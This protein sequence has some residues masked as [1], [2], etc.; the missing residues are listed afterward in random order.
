MLSDQSMR[1]L[2]QRIA[3]DDDA[4]ARVAAVWDVPPAPDGSAPTRSQ[5]VARVWDH[6][7]ARSVWEHLAEDER[8]CLLAVL[9]TRNPAAGVRRETVQQQ[10]KLPADRCAAALTRLAQH[11]FLLDEEEVTAHPLPL[12]RQR[13]RVGGR[14]APLADVG[15]LVATALVFPY[16]ECYD[17]LATTGRD[18]RT[19]FRLIQEA[20]LARLLDQWSWDAVERL[21]QHP[22]LALRFPLLPA[23]GASSTPASGSSSLDL[24]DQL[25]HL[26]RAAS[27]TRAGSATGSSARPPDLRARISERLHD[28]VVVFAGLQDLPVAQG[29]PAQQLFLWLVERGGQVTLDEARAYAAHQGWEP[30]L[31]DATVQALTGLALAFDT[32]CAPAAPAPLPAPSS[33]ATSVPLPAPAPPTMP[34]TS[35]TSLRQGGEAIRRLFLPVDL[36]IAIRPE[37]LQR[38]ADERHHAFAPVAE[39]PPVTRL[40]A[41]TIL[42]DLAFLTGATFQQAIAPTKDGAIPKRLVAT[43]HAGLYGAHGRQ[44]LQEP[45]GG[46]Q[47][48]RRADAL[49]DEDERDQR[50]P[51]WDAPRRTPDP[52]EDDAPDDDRALTQR[53]TALRELGVLRLGAPAPGD[54]PQYQPGSGLAAWSQL[55]IEAQAQRFLSWWRAST[56]WT[57]TWALARSAGIARSNA[58]SASL[59]QEDPQG[60]QGEADDT[61]PSRVT[62]FGASGV[63]TREALLAVLAQCLPGR[64]YRLDAILFALWKQQPLRLFTAP[65]PLIRSSLPAVW[66]VD[67]GQTGPGASSPARPTLQARWLQWRQHNGLG[68]TALLTT[69]LHALGVIALGWAQDAD[70]VPIEA[71]APAWIQLTPLGASALGVA[72][73]TASAADVSASVERGHSPMATPSATPPLPLGPSGSP[74]ATPSAHIDADPQ[75]RSFQSLRRV[76]W[77]CGARPSRVAPRP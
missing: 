65:A 42:Y 76:G 1:S 7:A 5:V 17:S 6:A 70:E 45:Q 55:S 25:L 57:D 68:F 47:T 60:D 34:L 40:G 61:P 9:Q 35:P 23:G 62:L 69:T 59:R 2:R 67:P 36:L 31:F 30:Y 53:F 73:L 8:R 44:A 75:T 38:A 33:V 12:G 24:Y 11:W 21:A 48:W 74:G 54:Y 77:L 3:E 43:L 64:W 51:G 10:T 32:L 4:I 15:E 63:A 29:L 28:P 56:E 37:A 27:P 41:P 66:G 50:P 22:H 52:T 20:P 49:G 16:R 18:L 19:P 14:M 46:P 26:H 72:P 58:P 39:E 13:R 71:T